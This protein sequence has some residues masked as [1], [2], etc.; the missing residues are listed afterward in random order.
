[1]TPWPDAHG[2]W[3]VLIVSFLC[4]AISAA[5]SAWHARSG[6]F[7]AL[8]VGFT[9]GSLLIGCF[10]GFIIGDI[11][12]N[13]QYYRQIVTASYGVFWGFYGAICGACI[14]WVYLRW[15]KKQK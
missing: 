12:P 8:A 5:W 15:S 14:G 11:L 1:M 9:V 7:W 10:G 6:I 13:E 2:D 4:G 3:I